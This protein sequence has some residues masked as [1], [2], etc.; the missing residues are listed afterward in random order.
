MAVQRVVST[1]DS[2]ASCATSSRQKHKILPFDH[3][4]FQRRRVERRT[5]L[6]VACGWKRR[7]LAGHPC[8]VDWDTVSMGKLVVVTAIVHSPRPTRCKRLV[9]WPLARPRPFPRPSR[10]DWQTATR[11]R[12]AGR[13]SRTGNPA[14]P[15][16]IVWITR[17]LRH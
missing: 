14:R 8:R 1:R 12:P 11:I 16:Q 4:R 3:S 17:P 9:P 6:A 2:F 10:V 13:A 15:T 7:R 5:G